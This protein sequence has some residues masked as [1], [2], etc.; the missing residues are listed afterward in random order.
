MLDAK[1]S[2]N[3]GFV[4]CN[5]RVVV[6]ELTGGHNLKL[7]VLMIVSHKVLKLFLYINCIMLMNWIGLSLFV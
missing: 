3:K 1:K 6:M 5:W 7:L 2:A 4:A